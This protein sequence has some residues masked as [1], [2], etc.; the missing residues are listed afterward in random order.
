MTH[1]ILHVY[2]DY[3][4]TGASEPIS[5]L[6]RELMRQGWGIELACAR[7]GSNP[8]KRYL[9]GQAR[10]MG[11]KVHEDFYFENDPNLQYNLHDIDRL[12]RLLEEGDFSVVHAHGSWDHA[13]LAIARRRSPCSAPLV[14][15][16]HGGRDFSGHWFERFQLGPRLTDHLVVFTD[17]LRSL[18]V[19][20]LGRP[21]ETVSRVRGAVDC[22]DFAP[23]A[24]PEGIRGTFGLDADDIV[25]GIVARVQW[26]R[27]FE[28]LL[29][30][31]LK[32]QRRNTRLKIVVL[33]RGT[34]KEEIL[35]RPVVEMGLE[36]TV[37]PLGYRKEDYREVLA[38]CDAGLM[39]VPGSDA[40][41]RAAMQMC[42]MG[43]P[44]VVA[45]RGVLPDIVRDGQTGA[46]VEDTP[47]KLAEALLRMA[48]S[49]DRRE[50]QG[51]A[52]RRRMQEKFSV[53]RQ[54]RRISDIYR[55]FCE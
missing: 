39:L 8:Q 52:A 7:S 35:D 14:R 4:W 16:D 11:L 25:F 37:Y 18:A 43:K 9:G 1:K 22:E 40:S 54:A 30:A 17:E 23:L 53:D 31:A 44:M 6:C 26:H 2:E 5:V 47:E 3:K 45:N 28:V 46:V 41:C 34:H 12:S 15:T 29:E 13:L 48:D 10:Q 27:R 19:R 24:P 49:P 21:P 32:F 50:K 38:M 55:Q 51:R 33:G 42:A 20:R 36:D